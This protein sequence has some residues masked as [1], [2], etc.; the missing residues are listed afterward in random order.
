MSSGPTRSST[1]IPSDDAPTEFER[2]GL[3]KT[4][5]TDGTDTFDRVSTIRRTTAVGKASMR[6]RRLATET[7][8]RYLT[9]Q[10]TLL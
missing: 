5:R 3:E 9:K 6:G 7:G 4:R 2:R 10:K 1:D 8:I